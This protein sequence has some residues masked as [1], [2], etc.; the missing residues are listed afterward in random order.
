MAYDTRDR[1]GREARSD[2]Y[3]EYR[4]PRRHCARPKVPKTRLARPVGPYQQVGILTLGAN[5]A[6]AQTAPLAPV[7]LYGRP[8]HRGSDR[9]NYYAVS[10]QHV[11]QKL[12][13]FTKDRDCARLMGCPEASDGD[14]LDVRGYG[15]ATVT[16]YT[17]D[18]A[19]RYMAA[20]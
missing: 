15:K 14:T 11:P 10:N 12:P 4:S 17:L 8:T 3:D 2:E 1:E 9:W 19:D 16:M 18:D 20:T 7:P 5:G 6:G 13:V